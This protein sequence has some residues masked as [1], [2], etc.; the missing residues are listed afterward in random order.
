MAPVV[1]SIASAVAPAAAG[2]GRR[3]QVVAALRGDGERRSASA[4]AGYEVVTVLA[5]R[6][7]VDRMLS[8]RPDAVLVDLDGGMLDVVRLCRALR[9]AV[10]ARIVVV[11]DDALDDQLV[12]D[13]LDAGADDVVIGASPAVVDARLRVALRTRP[14][15][16]T[17]PPVLAVGDVVVDLQAHEV[18]IDGEPVR[19]EPAADLPLNRAYFLT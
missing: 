8:V 2:S 16:P 9:D 12:V 4:D 17:L 10:D 7:V 5:D 6:R 11:S 13:V 15:R 3:R 14:G 1:H 18:R 19:L